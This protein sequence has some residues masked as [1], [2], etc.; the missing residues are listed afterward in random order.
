MSFTVFGDNNATLS[1]CV[2][3]CALRDNEQR[4]S[5]DQWLFITQLKKQR[6]FEMHI[7]YNYWQN[8]YMAKHS[9]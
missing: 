3:Q 6:L 9:E 5:E 4:A 8:I 2:T 7:Y 1:R